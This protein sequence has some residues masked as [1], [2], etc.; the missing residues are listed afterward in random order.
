[1]FKKIAASVTVLTI[2]VTSLT[3]CGGN[4]SAD[5]TCNFLNEQGHEKELGKNL[6]EGYRLMGD[7]DDE[8]LPNTLKEFKGVFEA[9]AKKSSDQE[10][11]DSLKTLAVQYDG[12]ATFLEENGSDY[13]EFK[14]FYRAD[15]D[16]K[17]EAAHDYL[18]DTCSDLSGLE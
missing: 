17:Y 5:E 1:M 13:S 3:A 18:D 4:L 2:A 12:L 7:G 11:T 15:E 16:G 9:A 6:D 8:L 14:A 10:M